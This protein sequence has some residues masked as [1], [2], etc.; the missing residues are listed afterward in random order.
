[1]IKISTALMSL[2]PNA[3]FSIEDNDYNKIVW[4]S[5]SEKPSKAAVDAE[6]LRLEQEAL[7]NQYKMQRAQ[8]YPKIADQLDMLYHDIKN[9]TL[10]SGA[11]IQAIEAVKTQ[12]PKP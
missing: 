6:I 8:E 10:D 3:K 12:Y 11:W 7:A 2:V 9:G 5:D 1:M 4:N